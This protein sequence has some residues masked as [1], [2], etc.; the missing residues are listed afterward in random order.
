VNGTMSD[1]A[2]TPL[3]IYIFWTT[4][5]FLE[6]GR[7]FG[8]YF[9]DGPINQHAYLN[10]LQNCFLSQLETLCIKDDP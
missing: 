1:K 6:N 2:M 8:T 3:R 4:G 5:S 7:L 10:T 9:F